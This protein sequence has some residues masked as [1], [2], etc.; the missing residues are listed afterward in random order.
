MDDAGEITVLIHRAQAGDAA[1]VEQLFEESYPLLSQLARAR[2]RAHERTPT[3]DTGSL[4]HE[5]FLRFVKSGRLRLDDRLHFRRWAA[6]VM[7]SVV[8][9]LA[10]R[11]NAERRGGGAVAVSISGD[12]PEVVQAGD[13]RILRLHEALESLERIDPRAAQVVELRYF[14]GMTEPEVAKALGVTDRTVRR[15]WQK[16]RLLLSEM[17][18]RGDT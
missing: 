6:R 11:R 18:D 10:R 9:D 4:V 12:L 17:L 1:A 13:D 3:L 15:D 5:A 2:L 16:A 14:A 8:I 7:R